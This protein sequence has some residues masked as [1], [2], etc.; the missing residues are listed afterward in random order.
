M[1]SY[2]ED[3][4]KWRATKQADAAK[5][6]AGMNVSVAAMHRRAGEL[7]THIEARGIRAHGFTSANQGAQIVLR[8]EASQHIIQIDA[9]VD[10][11]NLS[12]I[13]PASQ[14]KPIPQAS[15]SKR[16][17]SIQDVDLYI[18]DFIKAQES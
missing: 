11:Y 4:E 8:H 12:T 17:R 3:L 6:A 15:S 18:L 2:E 5:K 16:V 1:S 10:A 14:S 7:F 13:A 9:D